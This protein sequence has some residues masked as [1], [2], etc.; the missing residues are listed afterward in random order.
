MEMKLRG[1]VTVWEKWQIVIPKE[2]RDLL[3]I[4]PWDTLVTLSKWHA[5]IWLVK[6]ENMQDVMAYIQEEMS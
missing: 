4:K 6:N 5:A 1:S 3:N 2:V